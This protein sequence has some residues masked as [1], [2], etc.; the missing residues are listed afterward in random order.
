MKKKCYYTTLTLAIIIT[1]I[2]PVQQTQAQI[3]VLDVLKKLAAKVIKAIDLEVQRLQNNTI[4]LQNAQKQIENT[5][6]KLKLD[7]IGDWVQKQKDLY[8]E[9]FDELWK[10]KTII[11]YYKRITDIIETQKQLLQ[12]YKTAYA[13]I[14]QDKHFTPDEVQYMYGVYTGIINESVKSLDQILTLL[15]SFSVQMSDGERLALLNKS[16]DEIE[17]QMIDLRSFNNQN[18]QVS[19]QRATSL[20]EVNDIKKL[21]GLSY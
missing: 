13:Q 19:L 20:E 11:T 10:V 14:Q 16:A 2:A 7:E 4:D 21:Y 17:N 3:P 6:S 12:E 8:Q 5:L 1:I 15:N 18:I 9:Y